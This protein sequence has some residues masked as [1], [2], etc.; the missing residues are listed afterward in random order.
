MA[1]V[2]VLRGPIFLGHIVTY[3][4][5]MQARF[6]ARVVQTKTFQPF[7]HNG[8]LGRGVEDQF[9]FLQGSIVVAV[10]RSDDLRRVSVALEPGRLQVGKAH[11]P[12]VPVGIVVHPEPGGY[13]VVRREPVRPIAVVPLEDDGLVTA[14]QVHHRHGHVVDGHFGWAVKP[15]V[16]LARPHVWHEHG[17]VIGFDGWRV[18]F[19]Y[20]TTLTREHRQVS[21]AVR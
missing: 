10:Q 11:G 15:A 21:I 2:T 6:D 18:Q 19:R 13:Q 7:R 4:V 17:P 20:V 3:A 14:D 8:L 5:G 16:N 9:A 1:R 12:G